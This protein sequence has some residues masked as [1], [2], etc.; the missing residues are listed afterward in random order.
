MMILVVF[1]AFLAGF[2][3]VAGLNL[4]VADLVEDRKRKLRARLEEESRLRQ[5]ERARTSMMNREAFELA[6][7]GF[8]AP[9]VSLWERFRDFV[10]QSGIDTPPERIVAACLGVA[11]VVGVPVMLLSRSLPLALLAGL[12]AGA[13]PLL[14]V[15]FNRA[16][17]RKK[18]KSQLPDA[19]DMMGRVI[20]AGQT[21]SQAM[22][23]VADE[24]SSP[25]S[26]EFAYCWEQQNLGLSPEAS[27]RELAKRTG[28]LEIQIFVVAL[29]IHRQ[30]GG[31]L[32]QLLAKLSNVIRER[33]KMATKI[34]ALTA[35][36][37]MQAFVLAGLPFAVGGFISITN[38]GYMAPLLEY[39]I[40]FAM[41]GTLLVVG[42]LWMQKI[43]R[44]DY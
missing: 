10:S 7:A 11:A 38:P 6:A 36:G 14:V 18:L 40:I 3:V 25:I 35:E 20:R 44:F 33:E 28:V 5:A 19:Y 17:R 29:M 22:R 34:Q 1:I 15:A 43:I 32:A 30:T 39:P 42:F 13:I 23:G 16:Q 9:Q 26:E 8:E 4:L 37:Q 31:N 27:L 2:L 41:A 24:F 12:L 21:I